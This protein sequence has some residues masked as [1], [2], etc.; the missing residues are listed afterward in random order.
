MK[1]SADPQR[2]VTI[3]ITKTDQ[4][5][6]TS[7]DYSGV[8]ASVTFNSGETEKS[9]TFTATAD[10]VDDDGESVK[11]TFGTLPAGVTEGTTNATV[12]S[13]DDDDA[14]SQPQV[15][16]EVSF[17]SSAYSLME[18][19]T[20]TISVRLSEDP[21]GTVTI[22]LNTTNGT[23][24]SSSD[25]SG[26]PA[27]VTFNSGDT[28]KSFS[29]A[30]SQDTD[31]EIE[32]TVTLT[33]GDLPTGI[34]S[35]TPAQAMVAIRDSLRVSFGASSYQATEGGNGA[36]VTV[37]LDS[38]AH[39]DIV[40]PITPTGMNGAT[41]VDWTG[42]PN[43]LTFSI[44]DTE[45]TFT[46]MAYDDAV[47][48]DGESV[49]L[50]FGTLPAGVVRG[51][52]STAIV[53]LMN[54]ELRDPPSC[55]D[56]VWCATVMFSDDS[57]DD[58]G[59]RGLIYHPGQNPGGDR[60]ELTDN[61]ST[62]SDDRFEFRG[63]EYYIWHIT[64]RP[65]ITPGIPPQPLGQVPDEAEF[66]IS[67]GRW[68]QTQRFSGNVTTAH[69]QDWVLWVDG[70]PL[71]FSEASTNGRTFWWHDAKFQSLYGDW[72]KED[73]IQLVLEVDPLSDRADPALTMPSAPRYL[74]ASPS[75]ESL[76]VSWLEPVNDGGSPVTH[77][78][79]QWKLLSA[80]WSD[81]NAV[82]EEMVN[83]SASSF[84]TVDGLSNG[85]NYTVRVIAVNIQ[86]ESIPSNEHF[87]RPQSDWLR[88]RN[89]FVDGDTITL[90]YERNL[91]ANSVPD[92]A[93]FWVAVNGGLREVNS[94]SV[95]GRNVVLTLDS[96]VKSADKVEVNYFAPS[97]ASVKG[98]QDTEGQTAWS[99]W[100][101]E[102]LRLSQNRTPG[103]APDL[104]AEFVD[105][106]PMTHDGP[107]AA[108]RIQIR[109]SE[110]VRVEAGPAFA[111]LLEVEGAEVVFAWWVDRDTS[112]WEVMLVPE[113]NDTDITVVL[114][115]SRSCLDRGAPCASGER[116]LTTRL[117]HTIS[118]N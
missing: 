55:A 56:A 85:T 118:G 27:S 90:T 44:G 16:S 96:A 17:G 28:E 73:Q 77:Y 64:T 66:A 50:A 9:F 88:V 47:E 62:I 3:P 59:R 43:T 68:D 7:S 4:D 76:L 72:S 34:T 61:R 65:A 79:V 42:V 39:D 106:L 97:E 107:S 26:V 115:A 30:A 31:D 83:P 95:S 80:T 99:L 114:P 93:R 74:V 5:G 109:F 63:A 104:T 57:N 98:I 60:S 89:N 33:F 84:H 32:E 13:I 71:P 1:L 14:M 51:S 38:P 19:G 36:E 111:Y 113:D 108:L 86:G 78:L 8:P 70:Y 112:L 49:Q 46:V 82:S 25:Y 94:V 12:V 101:P 116:T 41:S 67:L 22:P 81:A 35:G 105:T 45:E 58:W 54:T 110:P 102:P 23:G 52:P 15:S 11:L 37:K 103:P 69:Y 87:G 91:D 40:I 6:A 48:D 20:I 92:P 29:F 2:T 100:F 53:Q 75:Y 18:G 10:T 24:V 21:E 117:E